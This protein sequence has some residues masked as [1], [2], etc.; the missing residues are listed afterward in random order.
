MSWSCWPPLF[1]LAAVGTRS[2]VQA[3]IGLMLIIT[4]DNAPERVTL[5]L[6]G[7]LAAQESHELARTCEAASCRS[8]NQPLL[9]DLTGVTSVDAA[10]RQF[11][12]RALE[13]GHTLVGGATTRAAVDEILAACEPNAD[14]PSA[15]DNARQRSFWAVSGDTIPVEV[16]GAKG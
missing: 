7:R 16:R 9:L 5:K 1:R 13:N 14:E 10:G 11:L 6:N 3:S 15:V 2:T 12:R 8:P 4:V